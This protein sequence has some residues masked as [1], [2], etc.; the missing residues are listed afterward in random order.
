M[1][2]II[3]ISRQ[4]QNLMLAIIIGIHGSFYVLTFAS[5]TM[6]LEQLNNELSSKLTGFLCG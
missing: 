3:I 5:V 2:S 6:L 4:L 1:L